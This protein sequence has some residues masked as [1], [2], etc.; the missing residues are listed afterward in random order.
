[1][2]PAAPSLPLRSGRTWVLIATDL[3]GRG[4]DFVG[5]ST[6]V[7]YD[8]PFT[9]TDYIHRIGRTGRAG[10]TGESGAHA[11]QHAAGGLALSHRLG[12]K[13]GCTLQRCR[14]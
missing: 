6:V 14:V 10:H 7:N 9:A 3:I 8:F 5:V 11:T 4:M 13:G 12:G 2:P 1:M